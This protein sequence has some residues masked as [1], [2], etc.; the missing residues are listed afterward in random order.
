MKGTRDEP[1]HR[2]INRLTNSNNKHVKLYT[3]KKVDNFYVALLFSLFYDLPFFQEKC[4]HSES[5]Q[6]P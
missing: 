3:I 6:F 2:L 5:D 4:T 1:G